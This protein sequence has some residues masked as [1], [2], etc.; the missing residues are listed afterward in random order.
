MFNF[1]A[2]E[3][4]NPLQAALN[5]S[6]GAADAAQAKMKKVQDGVK[7]SAAAMKVLKPDIQL[8]ILRPDQ[9]SK[10]S[11]IMLRMND[12]GYSDEQINDVVRA[13]VAFRDDEM[14]PAFD[15]FA[16]G[17]GAIDTEEMKTVV[18][19]IGEDMDEEQVRCLFR[20][21]D[22]DASGKIDFHEF[23]QMM[24][25]LTPKARPGG[26]L[27]CQT[28]LIQAQEGLESAIAAVDAAPSDEGAISNLAE[29]YAMLISAE[30]HIEEAS[31]TQ[32][33]EPLT[34]TS[35]V[36]KSVDS[37]NKVGQSFEAG[38]SLKPEVQVR[39]LRPKDHTRAGRIIQR[40]NKYE[41]KSF[42]RDDV[43]N[44]VI[45]LLAFNDEEMGPA[46]D[47]WAGEDGRIDASEFMEVVPLLGEDL[48]EEEITCM[49][50]QADKDA[51]GHIDQVEFCSMMSQMQMK[52]D[53][54]ERYRLVGMA[55]AKS[56]ADSKK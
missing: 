43:N 38:K 37:A 33:P 45:S 28:D 12:A 50:Q 5:A 23:C 16:G 19:L 34:P 31:A 39:I 7:A 48:T 49:F 9:H 15:L 11:R 56:Y 35:M 42:S 10:A 55:R 18:P 3:G 8:R 54:M 46:Y 22:K 21:A 20:V 17:D 29:A 4:G 27:D 40:M 47:L 30:V 36:K 24:Y 26:L 25:A 32:N 14:Q 13:L 52:G 44:V 2:T 41:K 1:N 51:S 53:G 6:K